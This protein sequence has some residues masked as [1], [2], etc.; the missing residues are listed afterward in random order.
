MEEIELITS[1]QFASSDRAA[2]E[3]LDELIEEIKQKERSDAAGKR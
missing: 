2:D 3:Q 1:G